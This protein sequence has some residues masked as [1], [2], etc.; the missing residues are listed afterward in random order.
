MSSL[1]FQ[2]NVLAKF[3]D[4]IGIFFYTYSLILCV[5]ALYINYQ[6]SKLDYRR[7]INSTLRHS[8]LITKISGI[9]LNRGVKHT[10]NHERPQK[11]FHGG[12][13]RHLYMVF[14]LLAKQ[15]K[16]T[17]TKHFNLFKPQRNCAMLGQ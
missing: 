9:A 1:C 10:H 8:S 17:F 2:T 15:C 4:I 11:L 3:V 12:Q 5:V 16:R 14:R 6:R 13:R 7:K